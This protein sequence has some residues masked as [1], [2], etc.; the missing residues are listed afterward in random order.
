MRALGS[1]ISA[2]LF[3]VGLVT[4]AAGGG[5]IAA[6]VG[7]QQ[8]L[9]DNARRALNAIADGQ[10]GLLQAEGGLSAARQAVPEIVATLDQAARI[11]T[12]S[13]TVIGALAKAGRSLVRGLDTFAAE[14]EPALPTAQLKAAARGIRTGATD[15]RAALDEM[16]ALQVVVRPLAPQLAQAAAVARRLDE[17][18]AAAA[19][20]LPRLRDRVERLGA[21]ADAED[22]GQLLFEGLIAVGALL[23]LL[24][25]AL[26][27]VA[28]THA[29]LGRAL[30]RLEA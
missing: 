24:G 28:F 2:L 5:L 7:K 18:L 14:F 23:A 12:Q 8:A 4:F 11:T 30:R 20:V 10:D 17:P 6:S 26:M 9:T 1:L 29:R 27:G 13:A 21:K 3:I 19:A 25:I 22:A 16:E 15:A